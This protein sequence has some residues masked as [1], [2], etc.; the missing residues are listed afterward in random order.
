MHSSTSF[1]IIFKLVD[2]PFKCITHYNPHY[3]VHYRINLVNNSPIILIPSNYYLHPNHI[4][5]QFTITRV[6]T[7]ITNIRY[8]CIFIYNLDSSVNEG[9][10]S[11]PL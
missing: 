2:I 7:P 5:F 3:N 9:A 10:S 1:A 4:S 8:W 11:F 6:I